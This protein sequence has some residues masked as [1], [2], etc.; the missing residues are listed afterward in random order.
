MERG[1]AACVPP[2][3]PAV[4]AFEP[5]FSGFGQEKGKA[6]PCM[7]PRPSTQL[8][9]PPAKRQMHPSWKDLGLTGM[10]SGGVPGAGGRQGSP[11]GAASHIPASHPSLIEH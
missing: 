4:V 11:A 10:G 9:I 6:G 2:L 1:Q 8:S 3:P 5:N 7:P